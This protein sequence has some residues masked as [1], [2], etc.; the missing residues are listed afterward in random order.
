[1]TREELLN[2]VVPTF[3]AKELVVLRMKNQGY[4]RSEDALSN[5]RKRG[6]LGILTRID[7]KIARLNN[8]IM[9]DTE[10][11]PDETLLDTIIDTR[12]Y[13]LLLYLILD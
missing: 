7:D 4:A 6:A 1:M 12:N 13:L 8:L 5:L 3:Q 10:E 2:E 9:G 11:L